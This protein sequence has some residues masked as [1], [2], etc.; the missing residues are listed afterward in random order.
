[1][2]LILMRCHGNVELRI[3]PVTILEIIDHHSI[4]G[5]GVSS[6]KF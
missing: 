3:V 5:E 6:T 4:C 2:I 1:M